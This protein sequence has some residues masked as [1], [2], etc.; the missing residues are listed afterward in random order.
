MD[1]IDLGIY[2]KEQQLCYT[3]GDTVTGTADIISPKK[4]ALSAISLTFVGTSEVKWIE[5]QGPLY[6]SNGAV[7]FRQDDF[8]KQSIHFTENDV[9][10]ISS[11]PTKAHYI[12]AFSFKI[13]FSQSLPSS[14][15]T[16]YGFIKYQVRLSVRLNE[17]VEEEE[18]AKSYFREIQV[19]APSEQNFMITV[20]GT[21]EKMVLL[22]AG[23]VYMYASLPRKGFSSDETVLVYVHIDNQTNTRV[24][25]RVTLHQVQT[26]TCENHQK[27]VEK[28]LSKEPVFGAEIAAN[29]N[30]GEHIFVKLPIFGKLLS[31]RSNLI[32]VKYF[33]RVTLDIPHSVD[34]I[35][36]LP[37]VL[38]PKKVLAAA[39]IEFL[40]LQEQ[41]EA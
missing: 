24:T 11:D 23:D 36:N 1:K 5:D 38:I 31:I 15:E 32:S 22:H 17:K 7:Y 12:I 27:T 29:A 33:L 40:K 25:P 41:I 13:T 35:I 18:E 28:D 9:T 14:M 3:A 16:S 20:S 37:I 39:K 26:Y 34:L 21:T 6:N 19:E 2:F 4:I 10:N 8:L 30:T